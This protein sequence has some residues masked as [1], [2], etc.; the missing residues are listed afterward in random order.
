MK[1]RKFVLFAVTLSLFMFPSS[2]VAQDTATKTLT[3]TVASTLTITTASLPMADP[4]VAYSVQLEAT[5]GVTPYIWTETGALPTGL[6]FTTA[7]IL[8]GTP[9]A[10]SSGSYSITF[11]V[12]DSAVPANVRSIRVTTPS[13]IVTNQ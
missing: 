2:A 3:L 9:G 7:G 6:T 12:T 10:S 13:R 5:G 8:S 1:F 4:N 11:T